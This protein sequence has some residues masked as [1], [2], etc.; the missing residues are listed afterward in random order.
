MDKRSEKH[1][2]KRSEKHSEKRPE[3]RSEDL[4]PSSRYNREE[5]LRTGSRYA[6]KKAAAGAKK[7]TP[8]TYFRDM[9]LEKDPLAIVLGILVV[10]IIIGYVV[11]A[12]FF[13]NRFYPGTTIF[14]INCNAK[15]V[16]WVKQ[17]VEEKVRS[18]TLTLQERYGKNETISAD[19]IGMH[20]VDQGEIEKRMKSQASFL[21]PVMMLVRRGHS[22]SVETDYDREKIDTALQNLGCFREENVEAPQNAYVGETD[23][24]YEIVPEVMGTTLKT[25]AVRT[26]VLAA[27]DKGETQVSLELGGC[28]VEPKIFADDKDLIA[29]ADA[30]NDLLGADITF[31]FADRKETVNT[32]L[33]MTFI[34]PDGTGGYKISPDKV[35]T[36]VYNLAD[37]YDTFG[38]TRTFFSTPGTTETLYGGDYGWA[39]DREATAQML[40]DDIRAKKV[41]TIEPVYMYK[42]CSR[43]VNDIGDT[44]VEISITRQEMWC[45]KDGILIV[46]TPIVSGNPNA[47]N[48]TPSGGV[49]AIDA[50]MEKYTLVGEGYRSPVDYWMPFNGNVGIHDMQSRYYFGSNIYLSHG[51][52]GCINTPLDAVRQIYEAVDIGTPVIVYE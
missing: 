30:K 3:K 21:W 6:E 48:A 47:G 24:G 49:W 39:M 44:Y 13:A 1:S 15:D 32:P 34:M 18:Y 35:W 46:D 51:S 50:K 23:T 17:E 19:D 37:K 22:M 40:L 28:Y 27:L 36:Y 8:L 42:G 31:D 33:I 12:W 14:G 38:G 20:Y 43:G 41:E 29:L 26:Q 11:V 2:E 52:H 45:Y 25:D 16:P 4:S 5:T 10:V 7:T 9:L